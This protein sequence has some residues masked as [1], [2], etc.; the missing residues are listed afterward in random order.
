MAIT[1]SIP[2]GPPTTLAP[3]VAYAIPNR[4]GILVTS[5]AS[6]VSQD[7]VTWA[8]HVSGQ[9]PQGSFVRS[10]GAAT[11]VSFKPM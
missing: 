7:N 8:A 2:V 10:A 3:N 4:A 11:I 1:Y 5:G 6:E 9:I